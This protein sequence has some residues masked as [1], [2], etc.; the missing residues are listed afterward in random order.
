MK[1]PFVRR[2]TY[3]ALPFALV[4]GLALVS[5]ACGS[6]TTTEV[7]APTSLVRCQ[8][9]LQGAPATFGPSGGTG[10]LSVNLSRECAWSA[11]TT[12]TWIE[13]TS[14]REGQGDGS[15]A[16]RVHANTDPVTRRAAI[17]VGEKRVDMTQEGAPCRFS[18]SRSG[19]SIAADGGQ[20]RVDISTHQACHWTAA[21]NVQWVTLAPPAGTGP[22]TVQVSA[23]VNSGAARTATV[24]IAGEP[25]VFTQAAQASGVPP[26]APPPPPQPPPSPPPPIPEQCSFEIAPG[27]ATFTFL[28]GAGSFTLTTAADCAWTV[29]SDDAWITVT[30]S[31][32]GSGTTSIGYLV[33]PN[34]LP[35]SRAGAIRVG[36]LTHRVQ[37]SGVVDDGDDADEVQVSGIVSELSGSCPALR[38]SL[39]GS[40]VITNSQT[41]FK[42]GNCSRVKNGLKV[43]VTGSPQP[44]STIRAAVVRLD[45]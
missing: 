6:S 26:P 10:S 23:A 13:I 1:G 36:Q 41:A 2:I 25:L 28:G 12:A 9:T 43:E 35:T 14:G 19:D 33:L 32:S 11:T 45:K 4:L 29:A 17:A 8:A 31:A 5:S 34:T 37:Q 22:G 38:F 27:E 39:G 24:V 42:G 40:V 3:P 21:A 44:D 7:T 16:Y 30:G 20:T 18:L 15:I